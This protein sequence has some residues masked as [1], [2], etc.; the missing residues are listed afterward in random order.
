MYVVKVSFIQL[1]LIAYVITPCTLYS[2]VGASRLV[3][4]ITILSP[5]FSFLES[6]LTSSI[7]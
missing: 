6:V 2:L 3:I 5:L 1:Y 4:V 7:L